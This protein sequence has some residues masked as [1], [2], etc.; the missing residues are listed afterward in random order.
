MNAVFSSV[1]NWFK[2]VFGRKEEV[3]VQAHKTADQVADELQ[4]EA[5]NLFK[6]AHDA[7]ERAAEI[8]TE[9]AEVAQRQAGDLL[10]ELERQVA[11]LNQRAEAL[12]ALA[13]E[14]LNKAA[15]NRTVAERLKDFLD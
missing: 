9:A 11:L 10:E 13:Q 12:K 2:D 7:R 8:L 15:N 5:N 1:G 4:S 14:R 3:I 6:Q